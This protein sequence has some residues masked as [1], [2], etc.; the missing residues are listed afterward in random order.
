MVGRNSEGLV[1]GNREDAASPARIPTKRPADAEHHGDRKRVH[2]DDDASSTTMDDSLSTCLRSFNF[3]KEDDN[4][5]LGPNSDNDDSCTEDG[6]SAADV[7]S[8]HAVCPATDLG[9]TRPNTAQAAE[10]LL[11][12]RES[13]STERSA[14]DQLPTQGPAQ[15]VVQNCPPPVLDRVE[16][17]ATAPVSI[18][19]PYPL[20][21]TFSP[22]ELLLDPLFPEIPRASVHDTFTTYLQ[23]IITAEIDFLSAMCLADYDNLCN[24]VSK[25]RNADDFGILRGYAHLIAHYYHELMRH[26]KGV[27]E[28]FDYTVAHAPDVRRL[29]ED[30]KKFHD[31]GMCLV[32]GH[33]KG[34]RENWPF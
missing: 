18:P 2:G 34:G 27:N 19:A 24:R 22:R 15:H 6:S 33:P 8:H 31:K 16:E 9:E 11:S 21:W 14:I 10:V 23:R 13:S 17:I 1:P 28:S 12:I 25:T 3:D 29:H 20:T 5:T 26:E 32:E 4:D 7:S 30:M